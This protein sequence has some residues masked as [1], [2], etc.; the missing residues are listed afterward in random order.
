VRE[1]RWHKSSYSAEQAECVEVA[2]L[3]GSPNEAKYMIAVRDSKDPNGPRLHLT[4]A[5]WA[6]F[7]NKIKYDS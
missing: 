2:P 3:P 7:T 1:P 6:N 5:H 4:T